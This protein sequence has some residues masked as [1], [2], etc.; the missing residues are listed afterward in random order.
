MSRY[1]YASPVLHGKPLMMT[2]TPAEAAIILRQ[3]KRLPGSRPLNEDTVA[4]FARLMSAG[5]WVNDRRA[6]PVMINRGLVLLNGHHRLV[7]LSKSDR[8]AILPVLSEV[9][10]TDLKQPNK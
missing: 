2:L 9:S 5:E 7:A 10:I 6:H 8:P 1:G 4:E 3:V